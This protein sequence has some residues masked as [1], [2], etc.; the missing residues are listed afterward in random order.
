MKRG[1]R[2]GIRIRNKG[3]HPEVRSAIVRFA[4]W[5][6]VEYKF[7]VRVPVYLY[8]SPRIVTRDRALVTAS[9]F[10]PWSRR[11]EPYIRIATGDYKSLRAERGRDN[12][13]AAILCSLA[14]EVIHYQT[15]VATGQI[16]ERGVAR[17]AL[18]VVRRYSQVVNRP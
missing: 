2:S 6:R 14:H 16:P 7:P 10:A 13:L 4:K 12:A 11:V 18:E 3:S 9:F 17:K 15:W 1:R 8:P 5:L